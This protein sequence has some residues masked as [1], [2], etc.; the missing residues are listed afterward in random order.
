MLYLG[1]AAL[2][3]PS[4]GDRTA[5]GPPRGGALPPGTATKA[6]D[7]ADCTS[8]S[9]RASS[10]HLPVPEPPPSGSPCATAVKTVA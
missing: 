3:R 7:V 9:C 6:P 10:V 4:T 2:G 8:P 5:P 1:S